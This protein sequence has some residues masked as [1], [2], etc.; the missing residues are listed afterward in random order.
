MCEHFVTLKTI[1]D[2][3]CCFMRDEKVRRSQKKKKNNGILIYIFL[4]KINY[5]K[6]I[7]TF[8]LQLLMKLHNINTR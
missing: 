1:N 7:K 3:I 5:F 4:C 6:N 8:I 2:G